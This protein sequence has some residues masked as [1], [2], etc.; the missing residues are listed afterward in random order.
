M[1]VAL[2]NNY[3]SVLQGLLKGGSKRRTTPSLE[4][5]HPLPSGAEWKKVRI[6]SGSRK[7]EKEY[8]QGWTIN[9]EPLCKLCQKMCK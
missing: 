2:G 9:D 3:A 8:T 6:C 4:I 1:M 7:K 5:S